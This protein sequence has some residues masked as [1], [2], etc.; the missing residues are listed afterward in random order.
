MVF[1]NGRTLL[2][3]ARLNKFLTLATWV[4]ALWKRLDLFD[5]G[6]SA[7]A[8]LCA[9]YLLPPLWA[10][11]FGGQSMAAGNA[12]YLTYQS[13]TY[14]ILGVVSFA[15]GYWLLWRL[16][17]RSGQQ[18]P[19][20]QWKKW[21]SQRVAWVAGGVLLFG[22]SIKLYRVFNGSYL[23][24]MYAN[25]DSPLFMFKY[26]ISLNQFFY[27][28]LAIAFAHYYTLLKSGDAGARTWG[29]IAWTGFMFCVICGLLAPGGRFAVLL[30]FLVFL[31]TRHYL[32]KPSGNLTFGAVLLFVFVLSPFKGVSRDMV[33]LEEYLPSGI[34][35]VD[36]SLSWDNRDLLDLVYYSLMGNTKVSG[37]GDVR[38]AL[39]G[40][41]RLIVNSTLGR[42]NHS[43]V[44][45]IIVKQ[46]QTRELL[47]GRTIPFFLNWLMVPKSWIE[48]VVGTKMDASFGQ[49]SGL[50]SDSLTGVGWTCMGDWY[51]NF[52]L[53]GLIG[54]M[55]LI[56]VVFRII[57]R[58]L[59]GAGA[60]SG[61][62]IY[63]LLWPI[64]I[65]GLEQSLASF[66]GE[67]LKMFAILYGVQWMLSFPGTPV[68]G[69]R[70]RV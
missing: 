61:I 33:I 51:Q 39:H 30:P 64:L 49:D 24:Y 13:I 25:R 3:R 70:V 27:V 53:A 62:F 41:G 9:M 36:P 26:F 31:V 46:Y 15:V 38:S 67:G 66:I 55:A 50:T 5:L 2:G 8:M 43:H 40:S 29:R 68:A 21:D 54:G 18:A 57:F 23:S 7:T 20:Q 56:G 17:P 52:G 58:R 10:F 60:T 42:V 6:Y 14:S 35:K 34:F 59:V 12:K 48:S 45:A 44:L 28:A 47:L 32:Y 65:H 22:I 63:S 69:T 1:G 11:L 19:V 37:S 4:R 16:V